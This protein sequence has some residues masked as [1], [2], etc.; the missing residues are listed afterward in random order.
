M[1][2]CF[3]FDSPPAASARPPDAFAACRRFRCRHFASFSS[4]DDI[5]AV[6]VSR[7]I[8]LMILMILPLI[9]ADD[10]Y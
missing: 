5:Y 3:R 9:L 8:I 10:Y 1:R 4:I 6:L 2:C 7:D